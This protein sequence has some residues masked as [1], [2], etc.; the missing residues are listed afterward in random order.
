M[1]ILKDKEQ[2]T[3]D[4]SKVQFSILSGLRLAGRFTDP[5]EPE[6]KHEPYVTN[7]VISHQAKS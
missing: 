2:Y 4:C 1:Y 6:K 5:Q 7:Y 3:H